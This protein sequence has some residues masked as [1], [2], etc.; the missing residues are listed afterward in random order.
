MNLFRVMEISGSAMLAERMRA[1]VV[2]ANLANAETTRTAAG[3]PYQRMHVV[4]GARPAAGPRFGMMLASFADLHAE[5][6]RVVNVVPD[7]AEPVRRFE[8]GHPDADAQ[9]YV[10]YPSISPAEE[11]VNLMGAARA[12]EMNASAV[13]STKNMIQSAITILT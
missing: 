10:S 4:F 11:L 7:T 3:G 13:N 1:E 5:D 8:P 2:S 12:Y 6:V 9:G